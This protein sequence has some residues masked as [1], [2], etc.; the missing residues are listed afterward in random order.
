MRYLKNIILTGAVLCFSAAAGATD[1]AVELSQNFL[2]RLHKGQPTVEIENQIRSLPKNFFGSISGKF[3]QQIFWINLYNGFI[4]R[5]V[6]ENSTVLND[7]KFLSKRQ[8]VVAQTKI[9]LNDIEF[10]FLNRGKRLNGKKKRLIRKKFR[11]WMVDETDP[12]NFYLLFRGFRESPPI[13]HL[14]AVNYKAILTVAKAKFYRDHPVITRSE[15]TLPSFMKTYAVIYFG[16]EISLMES[17]RLHTGCG[18]QAI[19]FSDEKN[20]DSY[21]FYPRYL[22]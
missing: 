13:L 11:N 7:D 17:I 22:P 15:C 14:T 1:P 6:R 19:Q 4:C 12:D 8:F 16:D 21:H 18:N 9:S 20:P 5:S 10:L 2:L 3:D